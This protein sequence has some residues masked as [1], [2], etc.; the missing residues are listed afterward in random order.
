MKVLHI[1]P[2]LPPEICGVGDQ[3]L[4]L[5]Q[6]LRRRGGVELEF[7]V[8]NPEWDFGNELDGFRIHTLAKRSARELANTINTSGCDCIFLQYSGYGFAK[9]GD[10]YWLS[11][12]VNCTS[13]PMLTMFHEIF[14]TGPVTSSSFW[15][16]SLMKLISRRL[17][18]RSSAII[19]NRTESSRWL[20]RGLVLP[21]FSN[22]GDP[23]ENQ[24][25]EKR[26]NWISCFPYQSAGDESYW[27]DLAY[28]IKALKIESVV[29]L[30]PHRNIR[31]DITGITS[32]E[33]T[34]LLP[35]REI[36]NWLSQCK[37][38]LLSYPPTHLGKSSILAG[39]LSHQLC[40]IL[41]GFPSETP[42]EGLLLGHSLLH[43]QALCRTSIGHKYIA[44]N[45]KNWYAS[46]NLSQTATIY[47]DILN[48]F[49]I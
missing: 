25:F 18:R 11:A 14:A 15:L 32:V 39:Y 9:R 6:E 49:H 7:L 8:C 10:P 17:A 27:D 46:H 35:A 43:A 1:V 42:S 4:L 47:N 23:R 33:Q 3:S 5:S 38:G 12:G 44:E 28:A 26:N 13:K 31:P 34:G 48:S 45:G 37:Y 29:A 2:K 22:F 30:G 36:S 19:T 24:L 16:S 41:T 21:V 20:G 40:T